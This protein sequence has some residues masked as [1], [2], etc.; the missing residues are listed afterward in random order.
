MKMI[1]LLTTL[2]FGDAVSNDA[3][4]IMKLLNSQGHKVVTYAE[5][6]DKRLENEPGVKGINQLPVLNDDDIIIYHLSTGSELNRQIKNFK[7]RKLMIYHNITPSKYFSAYSGITARLCSKGRR[8]VKNLNSTFD[9]CMCDSKYN[10]DELRQMG[11]TCPMA[12]RPILIP[13][14]DYK[15]EPDPEVVSKMSDGVKNVVFVGRIAPNKKQEDLLKVLYCYNRMF[16]E[17]IRLIL[18]GSSTGTENYDRRLKDYAELLELDNVIF[19]GQVSFKAILAYYKTCDAFLC[20]SEH[21]GFCVP[22]VEAMCFDKPIVAAPYAAVPDTLG[23]TGILL[24]DSDPK[25]AAYCLYEILHN[26]SLKE[27]ILKGQRERLKDFSYESI[28]ALFMEQ[29]NRFMRGEAI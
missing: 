23:G 12:V 26:E 18:V 8:E 20:M 2:S 9:A 29:L 15:K 13:F 10:M 22:L 5:N 21:E 28:S 17:K 16:D 27:D 4:A 7:G 6:L 19:T 3:L 24:E 1:Q 14:D 11:Y 25:K